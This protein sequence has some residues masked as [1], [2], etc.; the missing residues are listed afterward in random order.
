VFTSGGAGGSAELGVL[1]VSFVAPS[2]AVAA[3][4]T[5]YAGFSSD[6]FPNVDVW[7]GAHFVGL[8]GPG[9]RENGPSGVPLVLRLAPD[10]ASTPYEARFLGDALEVKKYE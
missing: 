4:G 1:T 3:D 6:G 8:D 7:D 9:L 5:L 2:L 10:A